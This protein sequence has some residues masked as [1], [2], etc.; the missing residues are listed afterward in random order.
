MCDYKK[1]Y[2]ILFNAITDTIDT[3]Q[4]FVLND[5]M[6]DVVEKLKSAQQQ[7]EE[8]YINQEE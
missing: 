5:T 1:M 8:I 3:M 2:L 6:H 7:C 4:G